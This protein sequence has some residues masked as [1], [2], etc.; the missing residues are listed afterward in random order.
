MF[1]RASRELAKQSIVSDEFNPD[2]VE[3][4]FVG[5]SSDESDDSDME[6]YTAKQVNNMKKRKLPFNDDSSDSEEDEEQSSDDNE[7]DGTELVYTCNICSHKRLTSE[8]RVEAHLKS[9]GH[10]RRAKVA[11]KQEKLER[12]TPEMKEKIKEKIEKRREASHNR[13]KAKRVAKKQKAYL[14]KNPDTTIGDMKNDTS[15]SIKS[16]QLK[17][18]K[19]TSKEPKESKS[20]QSKPKE[21]KPNESK[22]K[23][24][25]ANESKS[26]ESKSNTKKMNK[27]NKQ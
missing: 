1:K 25:K 15:A 23:K 7:D 3:E 6:V 14:K 21:S 10:I 11:A 9:K 19:S 20:K 2:S 17:S 8:D 12:L 22:S 4:T 13:K 24:S 27:I 18:T 16:D 5:V 26:K